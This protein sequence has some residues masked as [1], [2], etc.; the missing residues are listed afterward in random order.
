MV[1]WGSGRDPKNFN[2]LI[3]DSLCTGGS[4]KSQ[5]LNEKLVIETN[6][7]SRFCVWGLERFP[8]K[9]LPDEFLSLGVN[10][11]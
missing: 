11:N 6:Q 1:V 10:L 5:V 3:S 4:T 9:Q 2:N 8:L 7:G